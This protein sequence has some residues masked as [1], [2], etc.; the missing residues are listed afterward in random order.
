MREGKSRS[1]LPLLVATRVPF[2]YYFSCQTQTE[3][4][5]EVQ[6]KT[7]EQ[8]YSDCLLKE[9]HCSKTLYI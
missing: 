1:S 8:A 7:V 2:K 5:Y 6:E 9:T 3:P 4:M